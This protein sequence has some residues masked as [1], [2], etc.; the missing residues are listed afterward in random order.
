MIREIEMGEVVLSSPGEQPQSARAWQIWSIAKQELLYLCW[1]LMEVALLAPVALTFMSWARFWPEGQVGLWLL[2]LM[3][4]PFNLARILSAL[5]TKKK[6]QQRFMVG[7]L[8]LTLLV[9]WRLL[10]FGSLSLLDFSWLG[11]LLANLGESSS[12]WTR[13]LTLFL[14]IIFTWWRGLRLVQLQPDLHKAGFRLRFGILIFVPVALLPRVGGKTWGFLPFVLLYFLAGLTVVALIR[15]EQVE[16]ERSGFAASLSPRWVGAIAI[17]SILIIVAAALFAILIS[18]ET[19]TLLLQWLSPVRM[20]IL[21]GGSVALGTAFYLAS[22]LLFVFNIFL[23]WLSEFFA[24]IFVGFTDS[25]GLDVRISLDNFNNLMPT[26]AET[27]EVV[28]FSIPPEV[29]RGLI[30]LVMLALVILVSYALTRRFRQPSLT[31]QVGGPIRASSSSTEGGEGIG[32]RLLQRLGILRRWRTAASIRQLYQ[33]MCDTAAGAGYMRSP[34]ETP[35]EYLTT[36][37]DV[38]PTNQQDARLITE[39]YVRVRYGEV[40]ETEE[41]LQAI[42]EAWRRLDESKPVG[43][44]SR[45]SVLES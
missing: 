44:E 11:D 30:I 1:A 4:L 25:L 13:T 6:V 23:T 5:Q 18:G 39:A 14:L 45:A 12:L 29:T 16:R 21:A 17:I 26:E 9:S 37:G 3:L 2:L 36:L 38:W 24:A 22:P 31:R 20:A 35:Y 42:R 40:P 19:L 10:L 32:Q 27:A 33:A 41:E 8:L 7:A 28:G 34:S 15:A 43:L